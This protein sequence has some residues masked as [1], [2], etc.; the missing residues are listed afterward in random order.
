MED[1][2]EASRGLSAATAPL[3]SVEGGVTR[4]TSSVEETFAPVAAVELEAAAA[5]A[6]SAIKQKQ[7]RKVPK[8]QC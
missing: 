5:Q 7:I 2:R 3:P 1:C 6:S 4:E 8:K